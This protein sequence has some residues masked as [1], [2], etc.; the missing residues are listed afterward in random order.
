MKI[1]TKINKIIKCWKK[2]GESAAT[3]LEKLNIKS[4]IYSFEIKKV[5]ENGIFYGAEV[6]KL[7][8]EGIFKKMVNGIRNLIAA[9]LTL[10]YPTATNP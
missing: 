10:G 5:F 2:I 7:T 9:S 6:L 8:N 3:L 1:P 4:F